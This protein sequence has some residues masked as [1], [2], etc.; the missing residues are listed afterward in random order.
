MS[1][2]I[3]DE[4]IALR[5]WRRVPCAYYVYGVREARGLSREQFALLSRCDGRQELEDSP[6]LRELEAAGLCRRCEAGESLTDWQKPRACDNRYFPHINWAVTGKCNFNC[7][8]CFMASDNAPEM[9]EFTW[10]QCLDLLD[11]CQRCGVQTV[12][13]TGGEPMLHPR[14]MDLVRECARRRL[15][16]SE[17]NTNG[18]FV[19]NELLEEWKSLGMDTEFKISYDGVGH[20]DWL[21]NV[22]GAEEKALRAIRL[23]KEHGFRVRVQ[24]NV[25]RGNLDVMFDTVKLLDSLGVEQVRIIRTTETPR[26]DRNGK[27]LCLEIGEYYD[28]MLKLMGRLVKAGLS[29]QVDVWQFAHYHPQTKR[30][31]FHPVVEECG[32]YRDSIPLCR[33]ARGTIAVAH[34]GEVYPCNQMSGTLAKWGIRLGNVKERPLRELLSQGEYLDLVT[35]P[36]SAVKEKNAVCRECPYWPACMGGCR[37]I[38]TALTRDM[39]HYDPSKC[40]FFKGG[41]MKK[42]D[43][44]FAA[45]DPAYRCGNDTG[46][47]DRAGEPEGL[48]EFGGKLLLRRD[49]HDH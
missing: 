5:S 42:I 37:A 45:A 14:F 41:Y 22:P 26:W 47:M 29:I 8:H 33:G 31:Y 11:E 49:G 10:E 16:I 3:L 13:L 18:S 24:T 34:T 39:L 25:H 27:G 21:R 6:L 19:T 9:A 1:A 43:D 28:E 20:H 2:Y 44:A 12:T 23:C 48:A 7:L 17:V 35:T 32:C 36:V 15:Y 46:E 30:Y 38:A 4:A 40:L